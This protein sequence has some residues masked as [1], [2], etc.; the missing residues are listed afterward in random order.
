MKFIPMKKT[1]QLTEKAAVSYHGHRNLL[2][3]V[4][5]FGCGDFNHAP[6]G[7]FFQLLTSKKLVFGQ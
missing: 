7:D 5:W 3:V 2:C 4:H 6:Q 1:Y